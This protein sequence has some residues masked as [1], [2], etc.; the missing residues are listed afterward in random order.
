MNVEA[1]KV[2]VVAMSAGSLAGAARRLKLT[3]MAVTRKIA[4]L[5]SDLGVRL[6]HR[7]TRSLSLTPE[8]EVLMP[9]A[10]E[11]LEAEEAARA[12]V[13]PMSGGATGLLRVSAPVTLGRKVILPLMPRLLDEN[14]GLNIDLALSDDIVDIVSSGI[15]VAIRIAPMKDSGLIA[16]PLVDNPKYLYASPSY[17]AAKGV[18]TCLEQ[19]ADHECLTFSDTTHWIFQV[20]GVEQSVR[21]NCRFTSSGVDGFLGACINGLGLARLSAWD[22]RDEVRLGALV[23]VDLKDASPQNLSVWAV[24]PTRRYVLP[25]LHIFLNQLQASLQD[26]CS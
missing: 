24:Y 12:A 4:S 15:D 5:E 11:I 17:I 10:V 16:R 8:G 9:F 13:S 21:I 18:P 14:P 22:V 20:G 19:L 25:K 23:R 2:F 6:I 3:P 26:W 1:L 7:S